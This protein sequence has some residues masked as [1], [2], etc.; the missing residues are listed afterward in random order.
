MS[1]RTHIDGLNRGGIVFTDVLSDG[2]ALAS[3]EL[4]DG[5]DLLQEDGSNA[6]LNL[7]RPA[8]DGER[9]HVF[10]AIRWEGDEWGL[11]IYDETGRRIRFEPLDEIASPEVFSRWREWVS[12]RAANEA[13]YE[14]AKA[15]IRAAAENRV[16][17]ALEAA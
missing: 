14:V 9:E 13:G 17:E 3:G 16:R 5:I 7:R 6:W 12:V 1:L 4:L 2:T 8:I 10:H 15:N 11:F